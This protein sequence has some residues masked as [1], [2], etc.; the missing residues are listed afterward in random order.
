MMMAPRKVQ[1][2]RVESGFPFSVFIPQSLTKNHKLRTLGE[3]GCGFFAPARDANLVKHPEIEVR[4]NIGGRFLS[5]KATVQ[6][7]TFLP[8]QGANYFGVRFADV[9]SRQEVMLK[10][11]IQAALKKGHL[12]GIELPA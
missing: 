8:K 9:N 10:T 6:Y 1:R 4:F 3:G 12:I 2:F 5:F 7:C 11:I